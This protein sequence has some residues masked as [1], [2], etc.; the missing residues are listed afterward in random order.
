MFFKNRSGVSR[1]MKTVI[2]EVAKR[3]PRVPV[4]HSPTNETEPMRGEKGSASPPRLGDRRIRHS[5]ENAQCPVDTADM[6][7]SHL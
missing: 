3:R 2:S 1:L 4:A 6:A 7:V 5:F